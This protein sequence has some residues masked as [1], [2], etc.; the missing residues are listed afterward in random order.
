MC[1]LQKKF[2]MKKYAFG[3]PKKH[4][5]WKKNCIFFWFQEFFYNQIF[6][7][8]KLKSLKTQKSTR[9]FCHQRTKRK[10][11]ICTPP[12]CHRHFEPWYW[13]CAVVRGSS[14]DH[15]RNS[16]STT[17]QKRWSTPVNNLRRV[18]CSLVNVDGGGG[19]T[20]AGDIVTQCNNGTKIS[21]S[22]TCTGV[23]C[24]PLTLTSRTAGVPS[25]GGPTAAGWRARCASPARCRRRPAAR[26]WRCRGG[27][28]RRAR[29]GRSG[30]SSG[31]AG[32]WAGVDSSGEWDW[33]MKWTLAFTG[34]NFW[35]CSSLD[36]VCL[37]WTMFLQK[38]PPTRFCTYYLT[39]FFVIF[40]NFRV[41]FPSYPL[42]KKW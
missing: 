40:V 9:K 20:C 37:I 26:G 14:I 33:Q 2:C 28:P 42:P 25:G 34:G 31:R 8:K 12:L 11:R 22:V 3:W 35:R 21:V 32:S 5:K 36:V 15:I 38:K 24:C 4:A 17:H 1:T 13:P 23:L 29:G 30:G 7:S 39:H 16:P 18:R 6:S 19:P 41:I 10:T 27:H